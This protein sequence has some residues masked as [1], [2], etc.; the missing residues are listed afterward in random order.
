MVLNAANR[1]L[2]PRSSSQRLTSRIGQRVVA[3]QVRV[4]SLTADHGFWVGLNPRRRVFVQLRNERDPHVRPGDLI[5]FVGKA[6]Q[7]PVDVDK[8][9]GPHSRLLAHQGAFVVT[10]TLRRK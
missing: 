4:V 7:L 10:N 3:R 6:Q 8:P 2:L 9:G 5:S 1:S